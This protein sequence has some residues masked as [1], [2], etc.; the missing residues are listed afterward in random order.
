[1]AELLKA[2][3]MKR[4]LDS[5]EQADK[6][7]TNK[8]QRPSPELGQRR[9][10][11]QP[12]DISKYLGPKADQDK[13]YDRLRDSGRIPP[14]MPSAPIPES[15][16]VIDTLLGEM[17]LEKQLNYVEDLLQ[18]R[19]YKEAMK[20]VDYLLG[21][22]LPK[23]EKLKALVLR[24]K[25]LFH[26]QFYEDVENDYYR[27]KAYYP[28]KEEIQELKKYLERESQIAE[29][30][31]KVREN[32]A[33]KENQHKLLQMYKHYGWMDFAEQFFAEE[34]LD[35]SEPTIVSLCNV[36][37]EKKDYDMLIDLCEKVQD[38]YPENGMFVYNKGVGYYSKGD[39]LSKD[40]AIQAFEEARTMSLS[41]PLRRNLMWYLKRL[42]PENTYSRF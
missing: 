4:F 22:N 3:L 15:T 34:I 17:P 30:K 1:M 39:P 32:P 5:S 2:D 26:N 38:L 28:E 31:K 10:S 27:L 18:R 9:Q 36:Y 42:Q 29:L 8:R 35:I 24:E 14:S 7:I 25:A 16:G 37:Y 21:K 12:L 33:D 13:T 19:K 11:Y 41:T 40:K 6:S 23:E 20:T